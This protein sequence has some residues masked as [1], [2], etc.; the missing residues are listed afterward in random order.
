MSRPV[1]IVSCEHGG[2]RVPVAYRR[3]FDSSAARR[4]LAS[5]RGSDI[6][7]LTVARRLAEI[8]AVPL[9]AATTTRLLVDL[10]R[11]PRHPRLFS[12]FSR[13]LGS[14]ERQTLI[15]RVYRPHRDRVESAIAAATRHGDRVCHVAVHS[16]AP[17]LE[18]RLRRADVGLLY[19]PA[20]RA[21]TRLCSRWQAAIGRLAPE[22]RV[23][24]NY[25][26]RGVSDG[27]TTH[28][29]R[30]FPEHLYAGIELEL[31]QAGLEDPRVRA[32]LAAVI[33]AGLDAALDGD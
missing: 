11:S 13:K 33:A 18:G 7:A 21:E 6:G 8:L 16:F 28:L 27:L 25:P 12:E 14:A 3:L 30:R 9:H 2:N 4:A 22:L 5:H 17:K 32:H 26:Y 19:D 24:R 23:R 31:N 10:N 20:R 29:R 15:E 1:L